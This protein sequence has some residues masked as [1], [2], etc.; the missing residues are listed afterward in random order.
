M[1]GHA[2]PESVPVSPCC[3]VDDATNAVGAHGTHWDAIERDL[4]LSPREA[5]IVRLLFEAKSESM[6]ADSL[7]ISV[8]TVHSHLARLHRKLDVHDRSELLLRV[9]D[10]CC[11]TCPIADGCGVVV[12]TAVTVSGVVRSGDA[13]S[14]D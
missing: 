3:R 13:S 4:G 1:M 7:G 14:D 6:I 2:S 9:F 12:R 11:R 10:A 5:E 8:H